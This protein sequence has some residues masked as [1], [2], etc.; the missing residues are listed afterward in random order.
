MNNDHDAR[1]TANEDDID[2]LR[3]DHTTAARLAGDL[4][5]RMR[6]IEALLR[7]RMAQ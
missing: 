1:I 3:R 2:D 6:E 4:D 7:R 5:R